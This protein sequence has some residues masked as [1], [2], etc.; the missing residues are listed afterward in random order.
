M[1]LAHLFS[2][3]E[4]KILILAIA[5][6]TVLSSCEK[7]NTLTK[8]EMIS[9]KDWVVS[10]MT[11]DPPINF[12]SGEVSNLMTLMDDCEKDN[13]YRFEKD[14]TFKMDEGILNC[15]PEDPQ[16]SFGNWH[17]SEDEKTLVATSEE[18]G[19]ILEN[20]YE[21]IEV[22][23]SKIVGKMKVN[24]YGFPLTPQITFVTK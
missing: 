2:Q 23:S 22:T 20:E 5:L 15:H 10:E 1:K 18:N 17:L 12:G 16:I 4:P 21:L 6:T 11:I 19:E 13:I 8:E 9:G 14:G 3:S 7:D 24:F